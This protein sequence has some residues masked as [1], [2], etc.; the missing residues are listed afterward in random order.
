MTLTNALQHYRIDY[1]L[2]GQPCNTTLGEFGEPSLEQIKLHLL[3][4]HGD[5]PQVIEDA[6]WESPAVRSSLDTR[7]MEVGIDEI[8]VTRV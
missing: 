3:L 2:N 6:P 7:L 1:C 5:H 8:R 4:R